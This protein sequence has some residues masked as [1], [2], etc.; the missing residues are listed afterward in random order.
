MTKENASVPPLLEF[1]LGLFEVCIA[2]ALMTGTVVASAFLAIQGTFVIR[3]KYGFQGVAIELTILFWAL[4]LI[5]GL[6][7][8]N[9]E[10]R[11]QDRTRRAR[12]EAHAE[13]DQQDPKEKMPND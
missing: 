9:R 13:N 7:G 10:M 4:I 8:L 1:L 5:C 12:G 6:Y 11:E 2:I 3:D